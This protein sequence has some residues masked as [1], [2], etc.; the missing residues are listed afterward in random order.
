M[1]ILSK[2]HEINATVSDVIAFLSD[3]N[4]V[5][6]LLPQDKISEWKS[7]TEECSFKVQNTAT[8][9]LVKKE[10]S[11]NSLKMVS[12]EKSPFPFNL[13]VS[14]LEN[15]ASGVTGQI[16]FKGEVNAFLKMMVERPLTSL[17]DYMSEKLKAEMEKS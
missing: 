17:F 7:S 13:D 15:G 3:L 1:E 6:K 16:H 14:I 10:V 12:G 4:N 2:K 9:S 8:I 11:E 5:E